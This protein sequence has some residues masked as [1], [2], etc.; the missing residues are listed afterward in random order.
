MIKLKTLSNKLGSE[1]GALLMATTFGIFIMLSLFAFYLSRLVILESRNSGFHALDIKTR[2]LSLTAMEHGLQSF[3]ASR[4]PETI[5]GSFNRG[6][7]TV[8]FDSLKTESQTNLPYSHYTTMKSIAKINDVERNTRVILSTYP[9]AFCFSYYG[10]NT[11]SATFSETLGSI[12]GDMFFNGDVNTS[13]VSS[14]IIYNP[15]GSG[16][17]QLAS[18][19]IFPT[20]NTSFYDSLLTVASNQ[21]ESLTNTTNYALSFDGTND[22]VNVGDM[23]SQGA[24]TK[25]AW[26]KRESGVN[27]NNIISG[28]TGH[29]LW[30][31]SGY[32][33]KL[34]AGHN[35]A[36]NTVQ[37]TD[38]LTIGEW[39]FVAVTYNPDVASG[40]MVL[41]KNGTQIDNATGIAVQN[42]ST[43]TYV[44]SYGG[45]NNW[46]GSIDEVAIWN[47]ALTAAEIT[48]LYNSG[49]E[50]NA[51]A[52]YEN[53]SSTP[54]LVGYWK[55]NEGSGS[56]VLDS[57]PNSNTGTLV[58]GPTWVD[59]PTTS[60]GISSGSTINLSSYT[61]NEFLN[62][63]DLTL[64][65]VTVNGPGVFVVY[66]NL[67]LESNTIINKNIKIICSGNLTV[68]DSQL[69]TDLNS[70]VVIYS[71]G[72]ATYTNSTIYGLSISNGSSITLN[73]TTFYG[74]ILN[75]SSTF[76]LQG[77]TQITG[78]VVSYYSLDFQGG[79]TSVSK[80][81][82]PPFFRLD[83]GLNS[84]VVPGSYLEY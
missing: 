37:D 26:V 69:G 65:N 56:S 20:L 24:Y 12:T 57:S 4:N 39:N 46:I 23:L 78:S 61:N 59:G 60:S 52:N 45:G 38:A 1:S 55:M 42:E 19:P 64:S 22:Y 2:N 31:P 58:N 71:N 62:N 10:N 35:G 11:G 18:P 81:S 82:L 27:N 83:I 15:T 17:T 70:A 32:S 63:G 51:D 68:S 8:V 74:G 40:T 43:T 80:G 48:A 41:Y 25:I 66:G 3:K 30:A 79:S 9:E 6:T 76:A 7:Y 36:W 14:G 53:Y 84:I 44:G 67:T 33:Y 47:G 77:S 54:N 49:N 16:G 34:S 13:I 72:I 73:N 29:A 75:Y 50:L 28:N 5:Q 21:T